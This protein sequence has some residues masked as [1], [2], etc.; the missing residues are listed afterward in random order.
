MNIIIVIIIILIIIIALCLFKVARLHGGYDLNGRY[1]NQFSKIAYTEPTIYE[2]TTI[3]QIPDKQR[4]FISTS[5]TKV[6]VG[7]SVFTT[8]NNKKI[9]LISDIHGCPEI[10]EIVKD[11][12]DSDKDIKIIFLGDLFHRYGNLI[13]RHS[14]QICDEF[15]QLF[16]K[17]G[18]N[19]VWVMGNHDFIQFYISNLILSLS[20]D[21]KKSLKS[22]L[23]RLL[24][25]LVDKDKRDDSKKI[26]F[27]KSVDITYNHPEIMKR[28]VN[29]VKEGKIVYYHLDGNICFSHSTILA[30]MPD[31]NEFVKIIS[32]L[33]KQG[34]QL[35]DTVKDFINPFDLGKIL[36]GNGDNT[37]MKFTGTNSK[38]SKTSYVEDE[39]R[40]EEN[41]IGHS[42]AYSNRLNLTKYIRKIQRELIH[43][44]QI[45]TANMLINKLRIIM[46]RG[47]S[48]RSEKTTKYIHY[49]DMCSEFDVN[50]EDGKFYYSKPAYVEL[51][52]NEDKKYDIIYCTAAE[53]TQLKE[54]QK[55]PN[56]TAISLKKF[57]K[58]TQ[59]KSSTKGM[60]KK[61]NSKMKGSN[62]M[63]IF[64]ENEELNNFMPIFDENEE[65]NNLMF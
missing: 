39:I 61:M 53:S 37:R 59:N 3:R 17:M 9:L 24:L 16:E 56:F 11:K 45:D 50:N 54:I 15:L 22:A 26:I 64:N 29:V 19:F 52:P 58:S 36:W 65:L 5:R 63:S 10:L 35:D 60:K 12:L 8:D 41:F 4:M 30:N 31:N 44:K 23:P 20:E 32:E 62:Y 25:N 33:S 2:M 43:A 21:D 49:C 38:D 51:I 46:L 7:T 34:I 47:F 27:Q 55:Q 1:N 40:F 57:N 6:K 13:D 48:I 28:F 18:K 14:S 42:N